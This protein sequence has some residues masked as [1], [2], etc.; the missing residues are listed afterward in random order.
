[1]KVLKV[2]PGNLLHFFNDGFL[3]DLGKRIILKTFILDQSSPKIS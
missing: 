2:L 1:M 3:L